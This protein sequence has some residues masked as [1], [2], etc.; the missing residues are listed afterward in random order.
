MF[1]SLVQKRRSIRRYLPK[2]IEEEKVETL[3]ETALRA[4]SSR[5]LKPWEFVVVQDRGR[6]AELSR[7]KEAGSGFLEGAPLAFVVCADA[8]KSDVWMEDASIAS[9]FLLLAAESL[10]LGACW[11]QIRKRKHSEEMTSERYISEL[12]NIPGHLSV[13]S[14]IAMGYPDE[15]KSPHSK[16]SLTYGKV[17]REEHGTSWRT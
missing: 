6:L 13:E 14:I 1:L 8:N 9:T 15:Q 11:V 3:I 7:A 12:L 10:G 5:D 16:E 4:P 17:H 2:E